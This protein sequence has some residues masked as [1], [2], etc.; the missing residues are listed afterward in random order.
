MRPAFTQ[1]GTFH[2]YRE[3]S[4][5]GV[6]RLA[7]NGALDTTFNP[8][9][10]PNGVGGGACLVQALA[11]NDG[12][13]L[14]RQEISRS[15]AELPR[16]NLR[17]GFGLEGA[18]DTTFSI[19]RIRRRDLPGRSSALSLNG[20]SLYAAGVFRIYRGIERDGLRRSPRIPASRTRRSIPTDLGFSRGRLRS[21]GSEA[22]ALRTD[23]ARR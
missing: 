21:G 13:L 12:A 5:R 9:S 18:L 14:P 17:E 15:T 23:L 19:R 10:G 20:N 1:G 4:A 11:V 7:P 8:T 22:I 16:L 2:D 6:A 3:S